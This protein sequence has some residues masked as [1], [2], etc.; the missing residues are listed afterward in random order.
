VLTEMN[1]FDEAV[2]CFETTKQHCERRGLFLWAA[3]AD[4]GISQMHFLRGNYSTAL[5]ILEQVRRKHEELDDARRVGLCD[6]DRA[7][8]YLQ[9]NLFDD[10]AKL[11]GRAYEILDRLGSRYEAAKCLTYQGI[12]EFKRLNDRDAE[13][14]FIAARD[15][16][17]NEGNDLWVA[18]VDLWRAQLLLRQQQFAAAQRLALHSAEVFEKQQVPVRA[19]NARVLSAQSMQGL[20]NT[21]SALNEAQKALREVEGYHAPWVSYQCYNTLGRLM[22]LDGAIE[23]AEQL[24]L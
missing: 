8:I 18:V 21:A 3:I 12:A 14:S 19:A 15:V 10:A 4:R 24:Y 13:A 1:R 16:F 17:T 11:A 2:Q 6:M 7:E 23:E 5:R 9:L 20:A 22:E